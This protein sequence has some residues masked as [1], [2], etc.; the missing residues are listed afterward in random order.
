MA[1][2]DRLYEIYMGCK[3]GIYTGSILMEIKIVRPNFNKNSH[4][5]L[6][7]NSVRSLRAI[8]CG[9]TGKHAGITFPLH[10]HFTKCV[11]NR[12]WINVK[13]FILFVDIS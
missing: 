3:A 5:K 10:A 11:Q 2:F 6:Q 4:A 13:L 9:F 1:Y 8:I 12:I 7:Q